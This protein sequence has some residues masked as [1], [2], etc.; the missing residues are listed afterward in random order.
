MNTH[1]TQ[2]LQAA[3]VAGCLLAASAAGAAQKTVSACNVNGPGGNTVSTIASAGGKFLTDLKVTLNNTGTA[4]KKAFVQFTADANVDSGAELRLTF[5][6]DSGATLYYGPQ[7]LANHAEYY[8]TRST[9]A[10]ILVPPGTHTI[11]PYFFV[12]GPGPAFGI[13]DDRCMIVTF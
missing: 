12:Q 6:L 5:Q 10:V 9:T 7:N 3:L 1:L 13:L 8:Q 2:P 11:T 4:S